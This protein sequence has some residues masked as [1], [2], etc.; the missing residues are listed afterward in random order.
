MRLLSGCQLSCPFE[1][2]N[3]FFAHETLYRQSITPLDSGYLSST[4]RDAYQF[5]SLAVNGSTGSKEPCHR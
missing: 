4:S 2:L 3:E 1:W 5:G